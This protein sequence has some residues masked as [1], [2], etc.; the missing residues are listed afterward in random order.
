MITMWNDDA[1]A[2]LTT[3][4]RAGHTSSLIAAKLG[5]T[6]GAVVAKARRLGLRSGFGNCS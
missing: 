3:L 6:A 1:V 4:W 5:T 2:T